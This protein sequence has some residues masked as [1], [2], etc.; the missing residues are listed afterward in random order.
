MASAAEAE[1]G[2]VFYNCQTSVPL[3]ITL[4]ELGHPQ[5]P[6]PIQTDNSTAVGFANSTIKIKRTKAMDMNFHWVKDR[7]NN[8]EFLVYWRPG[9]TNLGEYAT[10]HH[11]PAHHCLVRPLYLHN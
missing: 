2:V 7:V 8:K 6:T 10:K 3:R 9:P 5:P 1:I 11:S 4:Q